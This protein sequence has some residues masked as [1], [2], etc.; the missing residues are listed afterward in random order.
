MSRSFRRKWSAQNAARVS[1]DKSHLLWRGHARGHDEITL[2]FSI[3]VVDDNND[4]AVP[5]GCN[6]AINRLA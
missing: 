1:N 3:I 6:G 5:Y 4:F 2:I